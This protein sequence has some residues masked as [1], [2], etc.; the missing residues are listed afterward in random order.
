LIDHAIEVAMRQRK[1]VYIE[2]ACNIAN[3]LTSAPPARTFTSGIQSDPS[4]LA[5]VVE[6]AAKLLN[7]AEKPVLLPGVSMRPAGAIE[8]CR[9]LLVQT[10]YAAASMPNAKSMIEEDCDGYMGIYW[11]P[12]SDPGCSEIV[13]AAD[14]CLAVGPLFTDDSTTGHCTALNHDNMIIVEPEAVRFSNMVYTKVAMADFLEALTPQ[15][16]KN[17]GALVTYRRIQEPPRPRAGEATDTDLSVRFLLDRIRNL[18]TSDSTLLVE[19]GDSWLNGMDMPLPGG[20]RFEIQMQYGSIG[21]SVGATLGYAVSNQNARLVS[22]IGDG[23]FQ[24]TAQKVSTMI[25]Y[26]MKPTIFLINNGG[27][28]IE[29]EIHDGPYNDINNWNYTKLIDVF[30]AEDGKG[31]ATKVKTQKEL[32]T[33]IDYAQTHDGLCFIE[34]LIDRDDCNKNLLRWGNR[35]AGNNGRPPRV[36]QTKSLE[37]IH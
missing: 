28:T 7:A 36:N 4:T 32:D 26:D 30:S 19:T 9:R 31:W 8:A 23:S 34:V 12:F 37:R 35:V 21:W 27:Y 25:R 17:D 18:I 1:P 14:A 33:A 15:L 16:E 29:V 5:A 2:I 24:L 11:G 6:H 13:E 22:C 20:A 3:A 10:S